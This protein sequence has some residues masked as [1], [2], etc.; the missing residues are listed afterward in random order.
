MFGKRIFPLRPT[1]S[2]KR[3]HCLKIRLGSALHRCLNGRAA[4]VYHIGLS[5]AAF[6]DKLNGIWILVFVLCIR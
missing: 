2:C 1:D 3:G 4:T 5:A 6:E